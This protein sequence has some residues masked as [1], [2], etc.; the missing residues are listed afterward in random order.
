MLGATKLSDGTRLIAIRNPHGKE[1]Y[2]GAFQDDDPRWR[3]YPGEVKTHRATRRGGQIDDG[4]FHMKLEDWYKTFKGFGIAYYRDDW[5]TSAF[6]YKG[7]E[8]R[9]LDFKLRTTATE[10]VM[11]QLE[12]FNARLF[13]Y[14]CKKNTRLPT[15]FLMGPRGQMKTEAGHWNVPMYPRDGIGTGV[16]KNVPAGE[17][18]VRIGL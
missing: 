12:I 2:K 4:T 15:A 13:P 9:E 3:N 18:T 5:H 11:L 10:D 14:G 16:F 8:R 17:V 1:I 7:P 6:R